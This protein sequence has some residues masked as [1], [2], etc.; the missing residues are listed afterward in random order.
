MEGKYSQ[1]FLK[2]SDLPY[3]IWPRL[4]ALTAFFL[5]TA[6]FF[7]HARAKIRVERRIAIPAQAIHHSLSGRRVIIVATGFIAESNHVQPQ[8]DAPPLLPSRESHRSRCALTPSS[9][10]ALVDEFP[11]KSA[12]FHGKLH[13]D[14]RNGSFG[15][16]RPDKSRPLQP[17]F[18]Y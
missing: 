3:E 17:I 1:I 4:K 11:V 5:S 6:G 9:T 12:F 13:S 18:P 7:E 8:H 14:H 16:P 10:L 15:S 2:M